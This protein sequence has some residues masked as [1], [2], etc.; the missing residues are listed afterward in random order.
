MISE[1]RDELRKARSLA[2]SGDLA[3]VVRTID[4]AL[5]ELDDARLVPLAE[6]A[7]LL[8]VRSVDALKVLMRVNGVQTERRG[9]AVLVPLAEV[10]RIAASDWIQ[11]MRAS[12]RLHDLSSELGGDD[13]MTPEE[14]DALDAGR[15][16]TLP[17]K[18]ASQ[19]STL[20]RRA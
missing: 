1:L 7:D 19:D 4:Q 12:D 8:G 17:W 3:G 9:E 15:P 10:E 18:R 11:H 20:D 13:A 14:L 2:E 5:A 6:A 16:G